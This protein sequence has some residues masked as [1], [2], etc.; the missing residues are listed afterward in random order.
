VSGDGALYSAQLTHI[1]MT[2][3]LTVKALTFGLTS[4]L[5]VVFSPA[6]ATVV[7]VHARGIWDSGPSVGKLFKIHFW[8]DVDQLVIR[9][10]RWVDVSSTSGWGAQ[11]SSESFFDG[12]SFDFLRITASSPSI[13]LSPEQVL[14]STFS[15]QAYDFERPGT[16]T[17]QIQSRPD[18][19][20]VDFL[21]SDNSVSYFSTTGVISPVPIPLPAS[22]LFLLTSCAWLWQVRRF[23]VFELDSV[24]VIKRT[25]KNA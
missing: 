19:G 11:I 2:R 6:T 25:V 9:D 23:R 7:D 5:M 4:A 24:S 16:G 10:S 18:A 12:L 17:L 13:P 20:E 3:R 21:Y 1:E 8:Y 22:Y 14:L 15:I